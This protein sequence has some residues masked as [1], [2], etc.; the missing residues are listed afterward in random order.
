[1]DD[2][3]YKRAHDRNRCHRLDNPGATRPDTDWLL[4]EYAWRSA[5]SIGRS[6]GL[7]TAT[8][9]SMIRRAQERHV[10]VRRYHRH[11][12]RA[13]TVSPT[14]DAPTRSRPTSRSMNAP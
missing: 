9:Y 6:L 14:S 10:Y 12:T 11:P 5:G 7:P 1:M 8:V 3:R 4:A 2:R 13:D